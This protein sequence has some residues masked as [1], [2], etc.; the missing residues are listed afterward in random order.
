MGVGSERGKGGHDTAFAVV[1]T[2]VVAAFMA[3]VAALYVAPY[4]LDPSADRDPGF[5]VAIDKASFPDPVWR[6]YVQNAFD[7]DH[8]GYL[9]VSEAAEVGEIGSYDE[10]SYEVLDEGLSGM[11]ISSLEGIEFFPNLTMLVA[12]DNDIEKLDISGNPELLHLDMRGNPAF[13]LAYSSKN[14]RTQILVDDGAHV[15]PGEG[16]AL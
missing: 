1:G 15:I 16:D 14:A 5:L 3:A 2:V 12:R 9:S 11:S 6:S 10:V 4:V 13:D 8:D 7:A